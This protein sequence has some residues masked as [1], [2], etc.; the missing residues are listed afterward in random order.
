VLKER[1]N[2]LNIGIYHNYNGEIN[3]NIAVAAIK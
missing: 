1:K 3:S 2:Q